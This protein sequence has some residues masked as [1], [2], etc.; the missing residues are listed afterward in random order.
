MVEPWEGAV[1]IDDRS[2]PL[3]DDRSG[4]SLGGRSDGR[5]GP[6]LGDRSIAPLAGAFDPRPSVA[7]LRGAT[8]HERDET[9]SLDLGF[10]YAPELR[11][12]ASRPAETPYLVAMALV[13]GAI[14]VGLFLVLAFR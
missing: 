3:H 8:L 5:S 2:G 10:S 7:P 12:G 11:P 1:L 4:P 6:S 9:P 14:A 13:L